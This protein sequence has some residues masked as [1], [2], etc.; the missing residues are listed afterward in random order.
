MH[1]AYMHGAEEIMSKFNVAVEIQFQS[2]S[3]FFFLF[4]NQE[5]LPFQL[6]CMRLHQK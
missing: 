3:S 1:A 2:K 4:S 5:N 6:K